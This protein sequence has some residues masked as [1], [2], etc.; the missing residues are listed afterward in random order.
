MNSFQQYKYENIFI[1]RSKEN[2]QW[3]VE[4]SYDPSRT[5]DITYWLESLKNTYSYH[6]DERHHL[7]LYVDYSVE[8]EILQ[9]VLNELKENK[10]EQVY[11]A[12]KE[13]STLHEDFNIRL[14][15]LAPELLDT[16]SHFNFQDWINKQ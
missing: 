12:V 2:D 1:G 9:N 7:I 6:S 14:F 15:K 5:N 4:L 16:S 10:V 13:T 11:F 3:Q 8:K